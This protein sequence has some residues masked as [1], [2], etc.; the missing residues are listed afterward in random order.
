MYVDERRRGAEA[1][2]NLKRMREQAVVREGDPTGRPVMDIG[3]G[4]GSISEAVAA[5]EMQLYTVGVDRAGWLYQGKKFGHIRSKIDQD[6]CASSN[7]N[8]LRR[9]ASAARRGLEAFVLVWASMHGLCVFRC[10]PL[11]V[12]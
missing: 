3:E 4:W 12:G 5:M 6:L 2:A 1:Q 9:A 10:G 8:V 11:G 7:R